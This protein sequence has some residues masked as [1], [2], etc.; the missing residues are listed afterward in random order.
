MRALA[1]L[2]LAAACAGPAAAHGVDTAV[3]GA[4][5]VTVTVRYAD[6]S[7]VAF[8][9][10]EV[11]APGG[12]PP[13]QVGRTD[14]RGRVVFV[15]DRAGAWTVKVTGEDGHG[16]VVPVTVDAA[17]AA[18]GGEGPRPAADRKWQLIAGVGV[19]LGVFGIVAM[20][21]GRRT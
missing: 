18:A 21:L 11:L 4:E 17:L 7:P 1:V 3:G 9:P 16:A 12:G 8:E 19:L 13:F 6:G 2:L 15:P 10:C 20:A 5:A 14:R